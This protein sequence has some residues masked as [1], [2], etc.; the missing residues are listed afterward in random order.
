MAD[1]TREKA[2]IL[3]VY[4]RRSLPSGDEYV[5]LP[6]NLVTYDDASG[7]Y[8]EPVPTVQT[9]PYTWLDQNT[10]DCAAKRLIV[11]TIPFDGVTEIR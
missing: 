8:I 3:E 5:R 4:R 7:Q 9:Q 10:D 1:F 2:T 11:D 6:F